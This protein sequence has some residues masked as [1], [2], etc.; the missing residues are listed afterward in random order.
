MKIQQLLV[1]VETQHLQLVVGQRLQQQGLPLLQLVKAY[2]PPRPQ[3]Q[4]SLY[5]SHM[6]VVSE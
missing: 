5:M 6:L 2:R 4:V 3:L 1:T